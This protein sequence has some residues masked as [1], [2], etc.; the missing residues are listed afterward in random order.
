MAEK[1]VIDRTRWLRGE[2]QGVLLRARDGKMCCLGFE[3]IRRG[4]TEDEIAG[5]TT[6]AYLSKDNPHIK[7]FTDLSLVDERGLPYD[8][9]ALCE[10]LT[11]TNDAGDLSD[12]ARESRITELF[13]E[14]DIEVEFVN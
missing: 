2:S 6:P 11:A 9:N 8:D 13:A 14:I 7:L 5:V 1:L 10:S 12:A 4:C 3:A